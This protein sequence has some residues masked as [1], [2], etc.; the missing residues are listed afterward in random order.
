MNTILNTQC[1]SAYTVCCCA[2]YGRYDGSIYAIFMFPRK[3]LLI[4]SGPIKTM[5]ATNEKFRAGKAR[6]KKKKE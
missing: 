4:V 3:L 2:A 5:P 6:Q 1:N